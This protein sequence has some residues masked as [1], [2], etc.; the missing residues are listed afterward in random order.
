MESS[1]KEEIKKKDNSKEVLKKVEDDE[2]KDVSGEKN[3]YSIAHTIKEQV[4]EQP[5]IMVNGSLKEYQVKVRIFFPQPI[6]SKI[7]NR[8]KMS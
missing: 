8:I 4:T 1:S 2:Y 3:Y 7:K 5:G 6:H